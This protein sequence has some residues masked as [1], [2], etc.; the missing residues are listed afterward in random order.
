MVNFVPLYLQL[1]ERIRADIL[2]PEVPSGNGRLPTER[3]LQAR[4][5]VSRPTISKA[6][7][8]LAA[9]GLLVKEQG[10]GSFLL[11]N[12]AR[13]PDS[14]SSPPRR[15]GYVAP[16]SGQELVNR[17]FRGIDRAAH[18]HDYR[19]LMGS[20]GNE[21][22]RE[23]AAVQ[24]LIASGVR[25]LI[26][27]PPPRTRQDTDG[28][29]L[30]TQALGVP[31][32]LVDTCVPQQGH[33]QVIFD[34]RRAGYAMTARLIARGHR[35]IG[36][37]SYAEPLE[38]APLTARLRGYEDAHQD[39][40][41][42][43]DPL[44][45]QRYDPRQEAPAIASVVDGWLSLAHPPTAVIATEDMAALEVVEHLAARRVRVPEGMCVVGFDNREAARRF[46]PSFATTSP[47]FERM[48][49]I[50]CEL[51]L[52]GVERG[53]LAPQTYVLETPLL[54]RRTHEPASIAT[55]HRIVATR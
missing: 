54:L 31:A 48:G 1:K 2:S 19:V 16:I 26:I 39:L 22:A 50:A 9:E 15:I 20:A 42:S 53:A 52:E 35:R 37:L 5:Q 17:I 46:R 23:R 40:G 18:R 49:E 43:V 36:I 13:L 12:A 34:N 10:R 21:V 55:R 7:A 32:V 11:P 41:L 38:H 45:M 44:L 4:Y 8:A 29:Y 33:A 27:Y 3:E 14:L 51:L 24:E 47:D 6:L 25:G 28:D 30:R